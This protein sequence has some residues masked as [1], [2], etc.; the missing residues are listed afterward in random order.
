MGLLVSG[1]REKRLVAVFWGDEV[2]AGARQEG[3][4]GERG[5]GK[6]KNSPADIPVI[7]D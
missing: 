3:D 5:R 2:G 7:Y 4:F 1:W 6:H